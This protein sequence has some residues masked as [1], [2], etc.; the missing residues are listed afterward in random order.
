MHWLLNFSTAG[1]GTPEGVLIRGILGGHG[2]KR[3][4]ISGPGR[5]STY[6]RVDR[7]LDRIDATQSRHMWLE[8]R[9]VR[10]SSRR[11]MT[12]PRVGI[13]YAGTYW[14]ARPWRFWID[15]PADV[16]DISAIAR[17]T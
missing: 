4:L 2:P 1:E 10:I 17:R 3:A 14:A 13:D 6:L 12:G 8:D 9:G 11:I 7:R 5:V 16:S 15:L